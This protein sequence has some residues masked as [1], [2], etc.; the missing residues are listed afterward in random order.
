MDKTMALKP[1]LSEKAYAQS[2]EQNTFVFGVPITAN[3]LTVASAVAAQFEV[4]VEEVRIV[5][6][7]G[8]TKQSYRKGRRPVAGKRADVKKAYVRLKAGDTINIF[9]EPED[10]KADKDTGKT[11]AKDAD[12]KKPAAEKQKRSIRQ[13]LSRGGSK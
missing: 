4:T 5:V 10:K 7:K 3:K 8:K 1:R 2:L 12:K 11:D 9:G 6:V 13:A